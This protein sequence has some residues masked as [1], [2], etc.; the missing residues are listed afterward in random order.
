MKHALQSFLALMML[1]LVAQAAFAAGNTLVVRQDGADGSYTSVGTAITAATAGDTIEIRQF[2]TAFEETSF[3]LRDLSLKCTTLEPATL[4]FASGTGIGWMVNGSLENLNIFG[5]GITAGSKGC[6]LQGSFTIKKCY[7]KGWNETNIEIDQEPG[8]NTTGSVTDCYL[9]GA[10][11]G[12]FVTHIAAESTASDALPVLFNHCTIVA[13]QFGNVLNSPGTAVTRGDSSTKGDQSNITIKNSI[14]TTIPAQTEQWGVVF[15]DGFNSC[16]R[17]NNCYYQPGEQI[18]L[19]TGDM[20]YKP[21]FTNYLAGD[22]TLLDTSHCIGRAEDGST[23][24]AFQSTALPPVGDV[25]VRQDGLNGAF[26]KVAAAVAASGPGQTIEIQQ[27]DSGT[28]FTESSFQLRDGRKLICTT[29][30]NANLKFTGYGIE[31]LVNSTIENINL[32]GSGT[33]S[34][35]GVQ[36]SGDGTSP[37]PGFTIKNCK[38]A[39]FQ[40]SAISVHFGLNTR[41]TGNVTGSYLLGARVCVAFTPGPDAM[42]TAD[43]LPIN[44]DHCTIVSANGSFCFALSDAPNQWQHLTVKNSILSNMDVN[45]QI[46]VVAD[47]INNLAYNH[48]YN[49]YFAGQSAMRERW[50]NGADLAPGTGDLAGVDPMFVD[51]SRSDFRLMPDSLMVGAGENQSTIG[52]FQ[53]ALPNAARD[54]TAYE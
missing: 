50:K 34:S 12:F 45:W 19:G 6:F 29:G 20:F 41:T 25:F 7:F 26:T 1:C 14:L 42:S 3:E 22:Y 32:V 21:L 10:R 39:N 31:W 33:G 23:I 9:I 51:P 4:H 24:G 11:V 54:W 2:T 36:A 17:S 40:E 8:S 28:T 46:A 44:F 49:L 16:V 47:S 5:D 18:T 38:I 52:A 27:F 15:I 53:I 13:N 43:C 48:S 35:I 37:A 30:E